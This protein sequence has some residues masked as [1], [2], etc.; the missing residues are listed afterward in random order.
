MTVCV[1]PLV[2]LVLSI[3]AL[4]V[5]KSMELMNT[6]SPTPSPRGPSP[7]FGGPSPDGASSRSGS[8]G[9]PS[10]TPVAQTMHRAG[11]SVLAHIPG[12]A[13]GGD[14]SSS[15]S[16]SSDDG[17]PPI[18]VATLPRPR[19]RKRGGGFLTTH[20]SVGKMMTALASPSAS[21][22]NANAGGGGAGDSKP[23]RA[24]LEDA[25]SRA[26]RA[27]QAAAALMAGKRY[28]ACVWAP[29]VGWRRVHGNTSHLWGCVWVC[30]CRWSSPLLAPSFRSKYAFLYDGYDIPR[31]WY[32]WEAMVLIRKVGVI[33][34]SVILS[35]PF[36]QV[37]AASIWMI[38]FLV[39]HIRVLPY[40]SS[41]MN[42][43]ETVSLT[44]TLMNMMGSLLYWQYVMAVTMAVTM[45]VWLTIEGF[46]VQ[47][48]SGIRWRSAAQVRVRGRFPRRWLGVGAD[49]GAGRGQPMHRAA[50][51]HLHGSYWVGWGSCAK[52]CSSRVPLWLAHTPSHL[53]RAARS[54]SASSSK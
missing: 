17:G 44:V 52:P 33:G 1:S 48:R 30:P 40:N 23:G 29:S 22:T 32:W 36:L 13:N 42:N 45:A 4:Q 15:S 34:L 3:L 21:P 38:F 26:L 7:A 54:P 12:D 49:L 11:P 51:H 20:D 19:A 50:V 43:L 25:P 53:R 28:I 9:G 2:L 46:R 27:A 24:S 18:D 6:R 47:V 16:S 5:E 37:F 41:L 14:P 31:G 39:L 8:F 35:D 10:P